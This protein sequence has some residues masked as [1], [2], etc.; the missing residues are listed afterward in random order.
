[1][2]CVLC[3]ALCES[4]TEMKVLRHKTDT[5]SNSGLGCVAFTWAWASKTGNAGRINSPGKYPSQ[6]VHH[7][8]S[9]YP[10]HSESPSALWG[11]LACSRAR[12]H[13]PVLRPMS[14]G[15]AKYPGVT[16]RG[17]PRPGRTG[18]V[19]QRIDPCAPATIQVHRPVSS[20][21]ASCV[22]SEK[23]EDNRTKSRNAAG[24]GWERS[25]TSAATT[26][27][28]HQVPARPRLAR[29][30]APSRAPDRCTLSTILPHP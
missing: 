1:M 22:L 24:Q 14:A 3:V 18:N 11:R 4:K 27:Y 28:H 12:Q 19:T 20:S 2:R 26:A 10:P 29:A 9:K 15:A 25:G 16:D 21:S 23:C 13:A 30:F 5:T 6:R 17:T 8:L 7:L